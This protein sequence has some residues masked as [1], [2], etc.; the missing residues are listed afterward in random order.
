MAKG[1]RANSPI[2]NYDELTGASGRKIFFR[3][4]R[5]KAVDLFGRAVPSV[6]VDGFPC[7]LLDLS[8][9][10]LSVLRETEN[11]SGVQ[12]GATV[13]L[14]IRLADVVLQRVRSRVIRIEP[15]LRGYKIALQ[16]LDRYVDLETFD[17]LYREAILHRNL[18][19][20]PDPRLGDIERDYKLLCADTLSLL[21][22][23]SRM[24]DGDA[25]RLKNPESAQRVL[26]L[27]MDAI[28]PHWTQITERGN[29]FLESIEQDP[30]R[31]E[32]MRRLSLDLLTPEFMPA[33]IWRHSY[34]KPL[35]YPGDYQLMDYV[36][37]PHD[38]GNSLYAQLVH[39]IGIRACWLLSTRIEA[40]KTAI[41]DAV[42]DGPPDR[43]CRIMNLGCGSARE[44]S[45]FLA[46]AEN[47]RPV[48]FTLIDQ[49]ERAL[50]AAYGR[51]YSHVLRLHGSARVQCLQASFAQLI[52]GGELSGSLAPQDF[53]YT[54]GLTDYLKERR[55]RPLV[56]SL[57][58][59]LAP[60]GTL[61]I[62]NLRRCPSSNHWIAEMISDWRMIF[63]TEADMLALTRNLAPATVTLTTDATDKVYILKVRKPH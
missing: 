11:G 20:L 16:F 52:K 4:E 57:Y 56:E 61:V 34:E 9:S 28:W 8:R 29:T 2:R 60:G 25:V 10:G 63:R 17:T 26:D 24:L 7:T 59:T 12:P 36:Y 50:D 54:V 46:E 1:L 31:L 6:L 3:P 55:A 39:R 42:L 21:R 49:D 43:P 23:Y 58:E 44:V 19:E 14:E 41:R 32:A 30:D 47:T 35:G 37:E 45:S 51:A 33:P 18:V 40:I 27:C 13:S 15:I 38:L 48:E 22:S 5:Y 62:A 53:I